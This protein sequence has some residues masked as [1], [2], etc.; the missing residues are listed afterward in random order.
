M[1]LEVVEDGPETCE[2]N[3]ASSGA[4]LVLVVWLDQQSSVFHISSNSLQ[5]CDEYSLFFVVEDIFWIKNGWSLED[6][7]S[8]R[9]VLLEICVS[10]DLIIFFA[11]IHIVNQTW[12]IW[13]G[14]LF[15]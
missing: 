9:R 11:E 8:L 14:K 1:H 15:L 3:E 13:L 2:V 6:I 7:Q 12:V 10:E 4:V 5:A